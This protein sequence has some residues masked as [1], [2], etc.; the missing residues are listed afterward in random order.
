MTNEQSRDEEVKRLE[1]VVLDL[2]EGLDKIGGKQLESYGEMYE[3]IASAYTSKHSS[4]IKE[5]KER[6][7]K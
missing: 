3:L 2:F 5:L 1:E 7:L 4:L 6:G